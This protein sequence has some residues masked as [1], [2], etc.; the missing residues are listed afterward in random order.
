MAIGSQGLSRV[1]CAFPGGR[2]CAWCPAP[3]NNPS[4]NLE[5]SRNIAALQE[6]DVGT[7]IAIPQ[8]ALLSGSSA[9]RNWVTLAAMVEKFLDGFIECPSVNRALLGTEI[10]LH[11]M[12][13]R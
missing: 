2:S 11:L 12:P 3:A 6:M 10:G 9:I 1:G 13:W 7:L 4:E 8:Q 5:G